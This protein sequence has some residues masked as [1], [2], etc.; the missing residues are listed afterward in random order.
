VTTTHSA[1]RAVV[2]VVRIEHETEE[3]W[4]ITGIRPDRG[5][6]RAQWRH[7]YFVPRVG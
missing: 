7:G 2:I 1:R 3:G 4:F 6:G 5:D